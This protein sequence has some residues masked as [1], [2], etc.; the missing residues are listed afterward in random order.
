MK[1]VAVVETFDFVHV[2]ISDRLEA[3]PLY[4]LSLSAAAW[5]ASDIDMAWPC[6]IRIPCVN[7]SLQSH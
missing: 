4:S 5:Y 3:N 7:V 6:L 1:I 2:Q